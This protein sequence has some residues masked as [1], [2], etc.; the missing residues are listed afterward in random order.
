[1]TKDE[2]KTRLESAEND[3]D[4][5]ENEKESALAVAKAIISKYKFASYNEVL[6]YLKGAADASDDLKKFDDKKDA[7]LR[8]A[9]AENVELKRV[10]ELAVT[11]LD[12]IAA[13]DDCVFPYCDDRCSFVAPSGDCDEAKQWKH[14]DEAWYILNNGGDSNA[15]N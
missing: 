9:I 8:E 12:K 2:L 5:A 6:A 1:M 4:V 3:K 7:R 10:L 14:R 11:D 13:V 15:E